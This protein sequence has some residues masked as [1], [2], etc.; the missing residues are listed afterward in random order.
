MTWLRSWRYGI[1]MRRTKLKQYA[2][3]WILWD[4]INDL[5]NISQAGFSDA[6]LGPGG[7]DEEG[8]P[9]R[10]ADSHWT[11][12]PV[13]L[14]LPDQG[15]REV[16][17]A[18]AS[19]SL[20]LSQRRYCTT[21]RDMLAVVAMCTHFR[22]YLRGAQFTLCTDHSSLRWLQNFAMEWDVGSPVHVVG[23]FLGYF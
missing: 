23:P 22:S 6:T 15:D 7:P 18:Y 9:L 4:I 3:L 10:L 20:H 14:P 11:R 2:S 17:I 8:S 12:M 19:R 1:G 13:F 5:L 16:V 21:H